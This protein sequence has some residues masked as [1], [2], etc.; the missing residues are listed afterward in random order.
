MNNT[1]GAKAI[2]LKW[3]GTLSMTQVLGLI[4]AFVVAFALTI[5]GFGYSCYCFGMLMIAVIL[6]M[7]PRM[8]GVENIKI[9][10]LVGILLM[11]SAVLI[12]GLFVTP[13]VVDNSQLAPP[14]DNEYFTDITFDYTPTGI[15]I[16]ATL[17][18]GYTV[19]KVY[20]VYKEVL[21]ITP[22]E[23][24]YGSEN[25]TLL[26]MTSGSV[27][28]S[29]PLDSNVLYAGKLVAT[30]DDGSGGETL[31]KESETDLALITE[32]YDGDLTTLYIIYSFNTAL[33][34]VIFFF[35]IM[36]LSTFMRKR[37]EKT[38]EKMEQEGRLYPQGYGRCDQCG[39]MVLPGEVNCRKCGAYI[40]RP[41]E[42]KPDKKHFFECSE[43]GAEVSMDAKICPKCGSA[44]DEEE[45]EV[46]RP[47]GT[48]EKVREVFEC[49]ECGSEVPANLSFCPKCG[50]KFDDE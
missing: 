40:D 30:T 35:M 25:K 14:S 45:T 8:L 11:V 18:G 3:F 48:V 39:A 21:D 15:D 2:D 28:G 27:T 17:D 47:D 36:F 4:A 43:C 32:L 31:I 20:F 26:T 50:A 10:T 33:Y 34:V 42:M 44:F 22:L 41:D 6:Y 5:Y 19:D 23:T 16:T 13:K 38:R 7:L 24:I 1:K 46:V 49:S 37:M 29:I 9:M 12:G